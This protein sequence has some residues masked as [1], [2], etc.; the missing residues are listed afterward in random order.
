MIRPNP[1]LGSYGDQHAA[2]VDINVGPIVREDD[3]VKNP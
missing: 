1:L 2:S 3:T